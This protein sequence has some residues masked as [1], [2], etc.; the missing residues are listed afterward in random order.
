MDSS[1]EKYKFKSTNV[2]MLFTHGFNNVV[3]IFVSTFL[4][5]YIYSLSDN[6]IM[7]IGLF[8]FMHYA[9][10]FVFYTIISKVIDKTDRVTFYRISLFVKGIFI[11]CVVLLGKNLAK[12]VP[13]AG[14]LYGFA[15]ACYWSSYNIMKNELV[16]HHIM[17][18]YSLFQFIDNKT[19][20]IVVPLILGKIID[21]ESF[22]VCAIIVFVS[23]VLQTI[24]SFFIKS[25]RPENSF[26]SFKEFVSQARSQGLEKKKIVK[27]SLYICVFYGMGAVVSPL[28]TIL[29]MTSFGSN[30]SLGILSSIFAVFSMA[31]LL[32]Y[33]KWTKLGKRCVIYFIS[34]LLP[35]IAAVL[36]LLN[37]SKTTVVI[38]VLFYTISVVLY[39][40]GFDVTRN[41][42]L[43]KLHMYD[44][45][46]EYQWAIETGLQ[47][48][49]MFIFAVMVIF[50]FVTSGLS[51]ENL[52]VAVRVFCACA[53]LITGLMNVLIALY[54][55]KFNKL[56]MTKE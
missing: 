27:Q 30:Y 16:S 35:V 28:T 48:G 13:L 39:E 24:I 31:L 54:E 46:A 10:M 8:Y 32:S 49:R 23:V 26:F 51:T 3:T 17:E 33:K 56:I 29:I 21:G 47:I 6:Y 52:Q 25:K 18:K 41:L 38:Y 2:A 53:I 36:I 4:V 15:E 11:L 14:L 12:M 55:N 45:I 43:K 37:L 1:K 44:S 40:F 42:I 50:G 5:S 34:A 22:K 7:N 19:I 9:S 20:N